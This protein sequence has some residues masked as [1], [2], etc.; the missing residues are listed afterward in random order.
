MNKSMSG[1]LDGDLLLGN[2]GSDTLRGQAGNDN[3]G[4]GTGRDFLTGGADDDTLDGGDDIDQAIYNDAGS[5]VT[6]DL[7][8]VGPQAVGGGLGQ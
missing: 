7:N 2:G 4:G 8:V 3:L 1:G 6:V 5:G